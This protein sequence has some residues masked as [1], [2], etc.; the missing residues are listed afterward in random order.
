MASP[1]S[2]SGITHVAGI[3]ARGFILAAPV[4]TALE[5]GFVPIRK[6][7]KLPAPCAS[8]EYALEYGTDILEIH[9]DAV[10]PGDRVLLVDD[11]IATGGTA[12]AAIGLIAGLGA[13]VIALAFYVELVF[14]GGANRLTVPVSAL[15]RY[16]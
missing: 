5:A 4:A 1:Y 6:Q 16:D 9:R 2:T 8:I 10:G 11:V 12:E 7:G 14:L 15:I 13:E 3:E